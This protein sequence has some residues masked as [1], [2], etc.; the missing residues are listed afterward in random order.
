MTEPV[1][2]I[3]PG[4][5]AAMEERRLRERRKLRTRCIPLG[6]DLRDRVNPANPFAANP[7]LDWDAWHAS[8]PKSWEHGEDRVYKH[9][10]V[11][12]GAVLKA[13]TANFISRLADIAFVISPVLKLHEIEVALWYECR[14]RPDLM[15]GSCFP[16]MTFKGESVGNGIMLSSQEPSDRSL[17]YYAL[18]EGAHCIPGPCSDLDPSVQTLGHHEDFRRRFGVLLHDFLNMDVWLPDEWHHRL[19]QQAL[20]DTWAPPIHPLDGWRWDEVPV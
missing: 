19:R 15:A 16:K 20:L 10:Q 1:Q 7:F 11:Q 9:G 4:Y 17:I 12:G 18:H 13:Y 3:D 8:V 6:P 14:T 2:R 5:R